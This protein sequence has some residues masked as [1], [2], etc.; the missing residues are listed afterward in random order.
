MKQ[1]DLT[2]LL[3]EL[4]T[5]WE[6][7]VVEFKEAND[8][9][10]TSDIG[11]Y[12][13]ALS[14]EA[15]LRGASSGWLVFGVSN[16]TRKVV[17]TMYRDDTARLMSLKQQIAQGIEP[18][19]T[20][21]DLHVLNVNGLRVILLEIPAAPR[22]IPLA[23]Q[24]HYYARNHEELASLSIAKFEEIRAQGAAE[25]WSAVICAQ[26]TVHDLDAAALARAREVFASRFGDRFPATQLAQ[27][28]DAEFLDT[29]KLSVNG[30]IPR[31]TLLLLGKPQST[32]HLS[33]YVAEL[34]WKLEGPELAYEHFHPPFL[35]ETSR[36]YQRI[37]N[38]RLPP[39]LPPGQLI[40]IDVQKY[41][42]RIVLEAL[43]NCVAHQDYGEC[44]RVLVIERTGELEFSNAG[45]FYDG[46]PTDY[47]LGKRIPK[48]YR[49]RFLAEAMVTL[50]MMDTMGFGIREVMFRGQA[51][52]YLPLPDYDLSDPAHVV[53]RLQGRFIDENYS[54]ALLAHSEFE[55]SEILALDRIQKGLLPDDAVV[56][57]L[58]KRGLV[59]GRKPAV[60]ISAVV[61]ALAGTQVQYVL[62][63]RQDDAHYRH[64]I[65]DYLSQF[66]ETSREKLREMLANKWPDGFTPEQQENKLH[67]L[68]TGL[69]QL[70][71]IERIGGR[72]NA[73][74]RPG[75]LFEAPPK[76]QRKTKLRPVKQS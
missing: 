27:F 36:L 2:K 67:N 13:S 14:N 23:W 29:A 21:R 18:S 35:L 47:V 30:Q 46:Q 11:K 22:G 58:R 51:N 24:G 57:Q 12:F 75:A 9:F 39:L 50:R 68:L 63:L 64:L 44:E 42:Q 38:L 70:Q 73:R 7:E 3:Q 15:N 25:D 1:D 56:R 17:G 31:G 4:I 69:R 16:K 59:E 65:L 49:N 41:D 8:N 20:L 66:G 43:H 6:N 61:A 62:A 19:T 5:T 76:N 28:S 32:H 10:S 74:W 48:R 40:P 34:T 33:P 72:S 55:W 71:Q 52:R 45:S 26:A 53:L 54:Q 60:H 37:R